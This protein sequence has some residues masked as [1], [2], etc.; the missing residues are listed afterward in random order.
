MKKSH[1]VLPSDSND[2]HLIKIYQSI[3]NRLL[4]LF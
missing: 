1:N 3:F 4:F 2:N